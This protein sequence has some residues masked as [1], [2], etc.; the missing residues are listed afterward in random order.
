MSKIII[1]SNR[2]PIKVV[3]K[4]GKM[5]FRQSSGG[6]A[7]GVSSIHKTRE[8]SWLGWPGIISRSSAEKDR[9][10]NELAQKGFIPVFLTQKKVE[11]YYEGFS[12]RTIWP[13]FHYFSQ[14][15][16]YDESLWRVYENVNHYFAEEVLK[17]Y[18]EGDMIWVHDYQLMLVPE[19]LRQRIP[20][21]PI[22]FFLHIPFP[23]FEI[24]RT[25][26]WRHQILDGMLGADLI[27]FHTFDYARHFLSSI[28]RLKGLEHELRSVR[29]N[30]RH[31]QID[32]FPMGIDYEK[33]ASASKSQAVQKYL[34]R[35]IDPNRSRKAIVCVDRLDY[36]KGLLQRLEAYYLFL[37]NNPQYQEKVEFYILVVP[38]R[39]KVESYRL[40]KKKIDEYVGRVN[41]EFGSIEWTPVHYFY[42]ALPF[43]AL[44]TLY[45]FADICMVTPLRD[46]MNL[47]AKEYVACHQDK[48]GVLILSEMAGA[49]NELGAAL[50]VN[51]ND[52]KSIVQALEDAVD[53]DKDEQMSRLE[54]MQQQLSRYDVKKWA[55]DFMAEWDAVL[56]IRDQINTHILTGEKM[57]EIEENIAKSKN[58]LVVLDY[59]GTLVPFVARPEKAH[60]SPEV[61]DILRTLNSSES[62]NVVIVSGRDKE[63]LDSFF[64]DI[65]IDLIAEHG[66]WIGEMK[67]KSRTWRTIAPLSQEWKEEI[68]HILEQYVA[69]T[70]GSFIEEKEFSLV[71]HYR[72]SD[73]GLGQQRAHEMRETLSYITA[74]LNL[75]VLEGVKVVEIKNAGINKGRAVRH[76]ISRFKPETILAAGDD[77]TDEDMFKALPPDSYS[78]KA[79]MQESDARY[80]VKSQE[81]LIVLLERIAERIK[82]EEFD[83]L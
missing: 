67:D 28:L 31:I 12:N 6:L 24:F 56:K 9:I 17:I 37:K 25:L 11:K 4:N 40:L 62:I 20:E 14:Y 18:D 26:P 29:Y 82:N 43:Y 57:Q 2:L 23:S 27:G 30:N 33:Y 79:N 34:Y 7:T 3:K 45:Y 58:A 60:P 52:V 78:I 41:G 39:A 22:G 46:G 15:T 63:S 44:V 36:S 76:L 49:A 5:L 71:W 59:D 83:R 19:I 13:L 80:N 32:S 55:S 74:N 10:K 51:P 8:T 47:V 73:V 1:V 69:R 66:A 64:T 70:P 35:F 77:W 38:S 72:Q 16:V 65:D 48:P 68:R 42:R 54:D 21:A 81:S 50:M 75:Q 61:V 53:M